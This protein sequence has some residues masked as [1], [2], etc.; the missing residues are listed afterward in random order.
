VSSYLDVRVTADEVDLIEE[1]CD[2]VG[3]SLGAS[4]GDN[5]DNEEPQAGGLIP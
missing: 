5:R 3:G 1:P 2:S 4:D